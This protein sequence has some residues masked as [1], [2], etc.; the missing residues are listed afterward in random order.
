MK[1][2]IWILVPFLGLDLLA[3]KPAGAQSQP[4][5]FTKVADT[6]TFVPP[7]NAE[8]FLS[9]FQP[10][11]DEGNVA[12]LGSN[13]SSETGI[14]RWIDGVLTE[15]ADKS[16]PLP[17]S[18][19]STKIIRGFGALPSIDG[20]TVM[21]VASDRQTGRSGIYTGDGGPLTV[22]VDANTLAPG[23][24]GTFGNLAGIPGRDDGMTF[25]IAFTE[26]VS[27]LG[28]YKA[29]SDATFK[30]VADLDTA[31]PDGSLTFGC[32]SPFCN[33]PI[34]FEGISTDQ[35]NVAFTG[36]GGTSG[37]FEEGGIFKWVDG[38]LI[39]VANNNTLI[40]GTSI[41]FGGFGVSSNFRV[42]IGGSDVA[43]V[44]TKVTPRFFGVVAEIDGELQ[45]IAEEGMP[46]PDGQ[47]I[48]L[49]FNIV[50]IDNGNV[51][52][53]TI[54]DPLKGIYLKPA[55]RDVIKVI[56]TNDLLDG[57]E[58]DFFRFGHESLSGDKL[59]FGVEFVD[60]SRGVYVANLPLSTPIADA[61]T[62]Q[63]V[64]VGSLVMLDGSGS[65][66][67]EG[68]LP[69]SFEW[70]ITS[71]PDLSMAVLSDPTIV[72]PTFTAD[73]EGDYTIQ[74]VVT[75]SLGNSSSPD[76]VTVST[77]NTPPVADAGQD[78]VIVELGTLVQ[79]DG[80]QS[81]D[82]DGHDITFAWELVAKPAGSLA[83]LS[84]PTVAKPTF[85]ADVQ[86]DYNARLIVTDEFGAESDSSTVF[87]S[88]NNVPPVADAG[89]N[90]SV[91]FGSTVLLDGSASSDANLDPLSF[92]WGLTSKP[93]GS[94]AELDDE[95]SVTP[96]F[97]ADLPGTYVASLV[98]NDG[99]VDSQPAN[100]TVVAF[101]IFE[102]LIQT[103]QEA[104]DAVNALDQAVLRNRNLRN[105][106][107]NKI[108]ATLAQVDEG[109]LE[110]ARDKLVQDILPKTEGCAETGAPDRNDWIIDCAAQAE[111]DPIIR[112]AI[113][114][115]M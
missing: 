59:A 25:F 95:T 102:K 30:V 14:Y 1:H 74:L 65:S 86:G 96:S 57:K 3:A 16:T 97:L 33:G 108:N 18:D 90:Q 52:F 61:G 42:A 28:V 81:F 26:A 98:V 53:N 22:V 82:L 36:G 19:G 89:L 6:D 40:P 88:F 31:I 17:D 55:D 72:N 21:L 69:L 112:E 15:I 48:L 114:L 50:S 35:G 113:D 41:T 27:N 80:S 9:F 13:T 63:P 45:I 110:E 84:D 24:T 71:K 87:V 64:A 32:P 83:E 103:L 4:I 54:R 44:G 12:F 62:N 60:G 2:L 49:G 70:E 43:F 38:E 51:A 5:T 68:D 99:F 115:L 67:P 66:D 11:I 77:F 79:L 56:D 23:E 76:V 101:V 111:V 92:Q 91:V 47:S 106:L 107:T 46:T 105:A 34:A 37:R 20:E 104:G 78:Q 100:V 85:V 10:S 109:L 93:D 75:D 7:E 8:A 73:A 94:L 29:N 58:I 39:L